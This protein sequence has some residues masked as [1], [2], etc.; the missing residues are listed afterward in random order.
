MAEAGE[1]VAGVCLIRVVS[2]PGKK[3]VGYVS[4]LMSDPAFRGQGVAQRLVDTAT[5]YLESL[6]CHEICTMV[7]GY[8]TAS[9]NRFFRVGYRRLSGSD[10]LRAWGVIHTLVLWWKTHFFFA[11]G[12]FFWV[13][14]C[15]P[16]EAGR[17]G[18]VHTIFFHGLLCT[19]IALFRGEMFGMSPP[20]HGFAWFFPATVAATLLFSLRH[21][22]LRYVGGLKRSECVYR[23]WSGGV[24]ITIIT[25]LLGYVFP[26]P[27]G[28]Y[29]R[30]Q[31]WSTAH[32]TARFGRAA[33]VYTMLLTA[34]L[35]LSSFS[36][37]SFP[38]VFLQQTA[39]FFLFMGIPLLLFDTVFACAPFAGFTARRLYDWHR[40]IWGVCALCGLATFFFL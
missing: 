16:K 35:W 27:G 25:A 26:L 32:Y 23:P 33:M 19:A 34:L 14:G 20:E 36:M 29:P 28:L 40:G 10:L 9:S 8:N 30:L 39:G 4:W 12:H 17:Y 18:A 21:G 37:V 22:V 31:E 1:Q 15:V 13:K 5:N 3:R 7:E 11:P 6:G 2:L 38:T 24:G